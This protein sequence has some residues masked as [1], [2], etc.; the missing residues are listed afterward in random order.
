MTNTIAKPGLTRQQ[1]RTL[2]LA[3]LGA[4]SWE[5]SALGAGLSL[6]GRGRRAAKQS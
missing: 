5:L 4:G 6:L 3:A 2:T 1:A